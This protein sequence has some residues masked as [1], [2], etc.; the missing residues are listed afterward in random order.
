MPGTTSSGRTRFAVAT[1]RGPCGRCSSR[2]TRFVEVFGQPPATHGAAGWQM[3]AAAFRQIDHWG[4]AY[5]SRWP[6][7]RSVRSAVEGRAP[8]ARATA[9]HAADARRVDRPRRHRRRQRVR[10]TCCRSPQRDRDQ[11]Y[12]LHAELEGGRFAATFATLIAGW[13]AQG[14]R[15]GTLADQFGALDRS[16]LPIRLSAGPKSRA[17]AESW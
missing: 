15:L 9:D 1:R 14:H 4:L 11:V 7:Q 3:N 10:G 12:T 13:R 5:A 17:G 2:S 6:R 8:S 16:T